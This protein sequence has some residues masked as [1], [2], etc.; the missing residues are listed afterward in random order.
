M[1]AF[2]PIQVTVDQFFGIE[3]N[4]FAVEVAK[5]ALWIAELQMLDETRQI[6]SM[7]IDPL[8]LKIND[9]IHEGNALR[10]DWND[11]VPASECSYVIGNPSRI[12]QFTDCPV[13]ENLAA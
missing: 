13:V 11:V 3:I 2:D 10:M 5:T 8:P 9:N 1:G 12:T 6:L 7:W 4:D